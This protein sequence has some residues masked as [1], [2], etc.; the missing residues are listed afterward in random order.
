MSALR[1][2]AVEGGSYRVVVSLAGVTLWLLSLGIF[3]KKYAHAT[4]GSSDEHTFVYPPDLFSAERESYYVP[5]TCSF[6][7]PSVPL[8][9]KP[10]ISFVSNPSSL[11]ISSLCSPS[12]GARFAGALVTPCI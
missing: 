7:L 6:C 1:R 2:R 3:D 5:F 8:A 4:A 9:L 11:R 10:S 12:S